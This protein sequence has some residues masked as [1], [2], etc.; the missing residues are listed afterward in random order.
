VATAASSAACVERLRA[1]AG[2]GFR[3]RERECTEENENRANKLMESVIVIYNQYVE[4]RCPGSVL[5][6][7]VAQGAI[8]PPGLQGRCLSQQSRDIEA[9]LLD[10]KP[11]PTAC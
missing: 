1:F 6:L 4:R 3:N 11:A 8:S 9:G 5:T 10:P 7:S 2:C